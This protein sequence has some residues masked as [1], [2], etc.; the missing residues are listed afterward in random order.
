MTTDFIHE[1]GPEAAAT[2]A[3]LTDCRWVLQGEGGGV[4]VGRDGETFCLCSDGGTALDLLDDDDVSEADW[5][6]ASTVRRFVS[7]QAMESVVAVETEEIVRRRGWAVRDPELEGNSASPMRFEFELFAGLSDSRAKVVAGDEGE[8]GPAASYEAAVEGRPEKRVDVDLEADEWARFQAEL[9]L[10]KVRDWRRYVARAVDGLSWSVQ[11]DWLL[12]TEAGGANAYPPDGSGPDVTPE[13]VRLL[14][15]M[16]R[17]L[18]FDAWPGFDPLDAL[19]A[20]PDERDR[21]EHLLL[22]AIRAWAAGTDGARSDPGALTE[23]KFEVEL[24]PHLQRLIGA[25]RQVDINEVMAGWPRVGRLDI[26]LAGSRAP[27]WVELK[28]AKRADTL[29]N[30][31]WDAAK[32]AQ[33][34]REGKAQYG[35][36]VA[37]APVTEW[38]RANPP[39]RLFGVSNHQADSLV[40]DYPKWWPFWADENA[41]TYPLELPSPVITVPVGRVRVAGPDGHTW[42]IRV[43]RV[44]APGN[45]HYEPRR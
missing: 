20:I 5:R 42:L 23:P 21:V 19:A 7:S 35:Y 2:R 38:Q 22:A 40:G 12:R 45:H 8:G 3:R 27:I 44:E 16:G 25:R 4:W 32:L 10:L 36:L 33:A 1:Q 17:L 9:L 18:G 6:A 13:F 24:F 11:L 15:V 29:H 37:G 41:N 34:L 43:A 39:S 14:L 26:E 30:C 28:W 31:L